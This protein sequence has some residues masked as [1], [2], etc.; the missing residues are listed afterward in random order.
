MASRKPRVLLAGPYPHPGTMEGTFGRIL[1]TMETSPFLGPH[2]DF[3]PLRKTIPADGPLP[4]RLVLDIVR[5]LRALPVRAD[6]MHIIMQRRRSLVRELPMLM[7]A[8]LA[9]VKIIMDIRAGSLQ[10]DLGSADTPSYQK[11]MTIKAL[12]MADHMVMECASD[13]RY[14][15]ERFGIEGIYLPN[16]IKKSQFDSLKPALLPPRKNEPLKLVY[17]GRFIKEK[18]INEVLDALEL[19]SLKGRKVEFHLVGAGDDGMLLTRIRRLVEAPP[20]GIRVVDHGF[21]DVET[22]YSLLSASHVFIM[23]TTWPGEGHSY[24]LNEAMANG[25]GLILSPWL[26]L[27]D[28]VPEGGVNVAD[29]ASPHSIAASIEEYILHPERL[30]KAGELNRQRVKESY[31]DEVRY[32]KLLELYRQSIRG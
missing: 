32:P 3:I 7:G 10:G 5:T 21:V 20:E 18:G 19:L 1:T 30:H 22:L 26:H 9:K 4:K 13:V 24:S 17:T 31:L 2:V 16:I 12:Q 29:A 15:R 8:R 6:A 11:Q 28:L 14:V 25:L 27:P 23:P